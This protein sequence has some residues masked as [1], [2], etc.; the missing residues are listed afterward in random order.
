[1]ASVDAV[2]E[3]LSAPADVSGLR[4]RRLPFLPVFVLGTVVVAGIGAEWLA[5]HD[6]LRGELALRN[7]PPAWLTGASPNHLLGTDQLGRDILSRILFGARVSLVLALVALLVGGTVGTV[8]GL[9]SGWYGKWVD[10]VIMRTVD[11]FL[12]LPLILVTLVLVITIGSSFQLIVAI[13]ASWIWVR[14]ARVVRGETLRLKQ[15]DHVALAKVAG[16]STLRILA[17]HIFPGVVNTLIVIATLQVG[18]VILLEATLSFL[19]AGV[20]APTPSWGSMVSDGRSR[21]ADAWWISTIP[22][23]AILLTL[24]SLNLFGDWLRDALDPRLRQLD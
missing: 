8:L 20:P 17:R 2:H 18:I 9:V 10:E 14:F 24:L 21:L 3:T 15:L 1:V 12:S 11:L 23:V 22:G 13:L 5:P 16:A 6:P 19:G 7:L 4:W